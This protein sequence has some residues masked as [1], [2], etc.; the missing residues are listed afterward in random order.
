MI[1]VSYLSD[2]LAYRVTLFLEV[3]K[4]PVTVHLQ[5]KQLTDLQYLFN[6]F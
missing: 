2:V 4:L 3:F 5:K 1:V 6:E